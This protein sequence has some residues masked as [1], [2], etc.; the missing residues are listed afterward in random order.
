MPGSSA[1][2]AGT[3]TP[4]GS[5]WPEH[6]SCW[7]GYRR[8]GSLL[9]RAG[10]GSPTTWSGLPWRGRTPC[11]SAPRSRR[12]RTP[13]RCSSASRRCRDVAARVKICG[14]TRPEDAGYAAEAGAAYLGVVFAGGPRQVGLTQAAQVVAASRGVPVLGV[15][16]GTPTGDILS[17]AREIGLSG[18]Q[19]HGPYAREDAARLGSAGLA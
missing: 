9:R 11:W 8:I 12:R 14:L 2:T 18:A 3:S 5:T 19:L 10:C 13:P 4:S 16:G 1:S 15:F 6:G 7:P 17:L